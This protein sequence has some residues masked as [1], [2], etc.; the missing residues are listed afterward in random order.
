MNG[1][2][3]VSH[4]QPDTHTLNVKQR[5]FIAALLLLGLLLS[6]VIVRFLDPSTPLTNRAASSELHRAA[7]D[8]VVVE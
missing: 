3:Q 5:V 1:N 7:G 8:V 6:F 4:A 2:M